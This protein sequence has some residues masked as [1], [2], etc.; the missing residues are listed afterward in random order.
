M[1]AKVALQ[2]A[3]G[4]TSTGLLTA[5]AA[6]TPDGPV[7]NPRLFRL[8]VSDGQYWL[9]VSI[10]SVELDGFKTIQLIALKPDKPEM[11]I[12][13]FTPNPN[14]PYQ[15]NAALTW[16]G[17]P[18]TIDPDLPSAFKTASIHLYRGPHYQPD[19]SNP[20][21]YLAPFI[22]APLSRDLSSPV[23]AGAPEVQ[24]LWHGQDTPVSALDQQDSDSTYVICDGDDSR[25]D[26]GQGW[27]GVVGYRID[28]NTLA[29][30]GCIATSLRLHDRN[31]IH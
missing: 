24:F 27:I 9:P 16:T 1:Q 12:V 26:I 17:R 2:L 3:F 29:P 8:E 4:L 11:L 19:P 18:S 21:S 15:H 5:N 31:D 28:Q 13:D 10:G 14:D 30:P 23:P 6:P 7:D 20:R 22:L 25:P